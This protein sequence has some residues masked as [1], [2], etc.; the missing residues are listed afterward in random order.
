MKIILYT[1]ALISA[2]LL[3]GCGNTGK[4]QAEDLPIVTTK[5]SYTPNETVTVKVLGELSGDQDWA[6]IF[7]KNADN[8]WGNVLAWQWVTDHGSFDLLRDKEPMPAGEYEAR[9]F[10]HNESGDDAVAK[11]TFGFS[12]GGNNA[13][14]YG[15]E[16]QYLDKVKVDNSHE[17]YVLYYPEGHVKNAPLVLFIGYGSTITDRPNHFRLEGMMKY[18]ASLGCYV[19]G[20]KEIPNIG[21]HWTEIELRRTYF[22]DAVNEAK[23]KG[24]DTSKLGIVGKSAGG[25]HS[26]ALM[27]Y[28]KEQHNGTNKSFII[29]VMGYLPIGMKE[30]D[31]ESLNIDSL[32]LHYG[33]DKKYTGYQTPYP[34][35]PRVLLTV[36]HILKHDNNKVGF[37]PISTKKHSYEHGDYNEFKAKHDLVQPIDAMIKYELFNDNGQ[38]D[39][40]SDILFSGYE[41]TRNKAIHDTLEY[42]GGVESEANSVVK[43]THPDDGRKSPCRENYNQINYCQDYK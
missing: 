11:G 21:E 18:V 32:I 14:V 23:V 3:T 4:K 22:I 36:A 13:Y 35:D 34:Q 31:L 42:L 26:Y 10:W 5:N 12:V 29:D 30:A 15:S 9:L 27:K 6:G 16:G 7:H 38:Y 33:M 2:L 43:Y 19:V 17:K 39:S 8:S 25:M 37:I 40:A 28:F 20:Q 24:V 41:Q 1:I